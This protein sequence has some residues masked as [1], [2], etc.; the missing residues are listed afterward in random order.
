[1][2][3]KESG[4]TLVELAISLMII[5]LLIG[6]VLKGQE[7]IE[8]ARSAAW[9]KQINS[10]ITAYNS[11][12]N[13]YAAIPGD[14]IDAQ[15]RLPSCSAD[16]CV[17]GDGDRMLSPITN[18]NLTVPTTAMALTGEKRNFWIHL[19][20]AGLINGVDTTTALGTAFVKFGKELP[21][22]QTTST[23]FTTDGMYD[24]NF[25]GVLIKGGNYID[26]SGAFGTD[27]TIMALT[28]SAALYIDTKLDDGLPS[29]GN[30]MAGGNY[31][32]ASDANCWTATGYTVTYNSRVC[33][34]HIL[35]PIE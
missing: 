27:Q 13:T 26:I 28:P 30:I 31:A 35:L 10:Y 32:A 25:F 1:M 4:F 18:T 2:Q 11:F 14:M 6:A 7:L 21:A 8:N 33:N 9:T 29:T 34:L 20:K 16:P 3:R 24:G 17:N 15:T 23:G 5:G 12:R 19:T 22:G